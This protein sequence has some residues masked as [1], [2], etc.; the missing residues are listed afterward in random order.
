MIDR[1]DESS[2]LGSIA[3]AVHE[4]PSLAESTRI[5][6]QLAPLFRA[7]KAT[8]S[9]R[10][11]RDEAT[12]KLQHAAWASPDTPRLLEMLVH[13][14]PDFADQRISLVTAIRQSICEH[15]PT[16]DHG[17]LDRVLWAMGLVPREL[18]V[19]PDVPEFAY[20]P[21]SLDIG[22]DQTIS[23]PHVVATMTLAADL[24]RNAN[25]LDVG[26]G[27]GYQ[28]AILSLIAE[29]VTTIEIIPN[30]AEDARNRL[31]ARGYSNVDVRGGDGFSGAAD[32]AP[33]D[34]I[35][36]AAAA[37]CIPNPLLEQLA[38]QGRLI[39]PLGSSP[40]CDQ[41]TVDSRSPSGETVIRSLGAVRFVP[42]TGKGQREAPGLT[43]AN[44]H[45][46]SHS[47]RSRTRERSGD[48]C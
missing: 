47:P 44:E 24:P 7:E 17:K 23:N 28:A 22:H 29:T 8:V 38:P 1:K 20:L 32:R 10:S 37:A 43:M 2:S 34:A 25:V 42:L 14:P 13:L 30:L 15:D 31:G 5:W 12:P 36:V 48:G 4:E 21:T 19:H 26:T 27:S 18:F 40:E 46:C 45:V 41:L 11:S 33:F 16:A 9:P 35:I 39:M 6:R 3:S